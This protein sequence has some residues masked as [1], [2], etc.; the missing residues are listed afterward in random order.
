MQHGSNE[1]LA[2]RG[3]DIIPFHWRVRR[4]GAT[5]LGHILQSIGWR[6]APQGG[7]ESTASKKHTQLVGFLVIDVVHG[8]LDAKAAVRMRLNSIVVFREEF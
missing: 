2:T 5:W 8:V 4:E 3:A 1:R 7:P 6:T